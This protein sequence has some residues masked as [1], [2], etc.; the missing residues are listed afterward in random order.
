[1]NDIANGVTKQRPVFCSQPNGDSAM[2]DASNRGAAE[3]A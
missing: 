2:Q 3:R 1:M